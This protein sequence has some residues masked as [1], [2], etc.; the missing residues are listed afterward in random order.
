MTE[1][2]ASQIRE[3][4]RCNLLILPSHEYSQKMGNMIYYKPFALMLEINSLRNKC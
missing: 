4:K 3:N 1:Q 2:Q